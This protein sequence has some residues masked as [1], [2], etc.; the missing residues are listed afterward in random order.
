MGLRF[1]I[2]L[3]ID[4][5][6]FGPDI[7]HQIHHLIALNPPTKVPWDNKLLFHVSAIL[8]RIVGV[9]GI[10]EW[11]CL[12]FGNVNIVEKLLCLFE[13]RILIQRSVVGLVVG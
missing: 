12:G 7:F 3:L 4:T 10:L 1:L 6:D 9:S 11:V 8:L 5:V 2:M 13:V